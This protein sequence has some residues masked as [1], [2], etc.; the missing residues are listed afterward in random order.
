MRNPFAAHDPSLKGRPSFPLSA[1][2][3]VKIALNNAKLS[4][5]L[6]PYLPAN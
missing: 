1:C 3:A 2:F 6:T 4:R 5:I